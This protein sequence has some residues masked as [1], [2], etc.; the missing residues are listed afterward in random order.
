[1]VLGC[2]CSLPEIT[3]RFLRVRRGL[4]DTIGV[5]GIV[6]ATYLII[7]KELNGELKICSQTNIGVKVY[8]EIPI[9]EV[10]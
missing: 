7:I 10:S 3:K 5:L 6:L 1:M 8:I 2:V 9:V 4:T